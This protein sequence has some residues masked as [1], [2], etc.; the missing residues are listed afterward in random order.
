MAK[1]FY[2]ITM[3]GRPAPGEVE[4]KSTDFVKGYTLSDHIRMMQHRNSKISDM[5]F[6][7]RLD[8]GLCDY[9]IEQERIKQQAPQKLYYQVWER[10]CD[11]MESYSLLTASS[12]ADAEYKMNE[13]YNNAEGPVEIIAI[14]EEEAAEFKASSFDRVA[15]QAGY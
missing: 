3:Q 15:Y 9:H 2:T 7:W 4:F 10:D 1:L 13:I 6:V 5:K 14:T 8:F 12:F 11:L